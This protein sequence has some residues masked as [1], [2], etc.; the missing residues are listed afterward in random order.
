MDEVLK[1]KDTGEF[2]KK[3]KEQIAL[4]DKYKE[5]TKG[6][7]VPQFEE[8][9]D[10][11]KK[12]ILP[13]S[14]KQRIFDEK[15]RT[16][17]MMRNDLEADINMLR[18]AYEKL[19]AEN[20]ERLRNIGKIGATSEFGIALTR[21]QEIFIKALP[22]INFKDIQ[23]R[24]NLLA[25][26]ID[27]FTKAP[28]K[29]GAESVINQS[30]E[31]LQTLEPLA[32]KL[33]GAGTNIDLAAAKTIENYINRL[34]YIITELRGDEVNKALVDNILKQRKIEAS[35]NTLYT[36]ME[37]SF[38]IQIKYLNL[39]TENASKFES[40]YERIGKAVDKLAI[41]QKE[42][43]LGA[44]NMR[45]YEGLAAFYGYPEPKAF[46]GHVHGSDNIPA[47]LSHGEYVV[48][49]GASRKF[50]SQ[51]VAMNSGVKRFASGGSVIN[52]DF[53]VTL[54]SS[55][56]EHVDVVRIG[57]ALRREIRRGTVSLV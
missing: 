5:M 56:N 45:E 8:M 2:T 35:L 27:L 11:L 57:K 32:K 38:G 51:L 55:G 53:N 47:L 22:S 26:N 23:E 1:I 34:K 6:K 33:R 54:Q 48:N 36:K 4:I 50:Y 20:N 40:I 12:V 49:A 25:G 18:V 43:T 39:A 29:T 10:V 42:L 28:T 3:I 24:A 21:M 37:A 14:L 13:E 46:G 31:L 30:K 16:S 15:L 7:A 41:S 9:R 19:E 52:G 17:Q 44:F